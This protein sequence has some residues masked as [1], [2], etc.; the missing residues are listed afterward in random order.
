M[1]ALT[2]LL[3]AVSSVGQTGGD[4]R[5]VVEVRLPAEASLTVDGV[6]TTQTGAVRTF[7][8]PALPRGRTF[9]YELVAVWQE[10]GLTLKRV[11][12]A[13]VRAGERT[14]VDF[15]AAD[16]KSGE[17]GPVGKAGTPKSRTFL[18]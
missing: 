16:P 9:S 4:T 13:S 8:T 7:Y 14:I 5:A 1:S 11:R 17:K 12:T 3:L 2:C 15:N 6:K 18:F 10:E